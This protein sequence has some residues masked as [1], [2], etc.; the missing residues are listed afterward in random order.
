MVQEITLTSSTR[1]CVS[2]DNFLGYEGENK[3][4]KLV[5]AFTD[6]F[7]DGLGTLNIKRENEVGY[8]ELDKVGETYEF[9]VRNSILGKIG[10]I[11]F[12]VSITKSDGTVIK[13]DQFMKTVKDAIDTDAE[14]PEDYPTWLDMGNA[15]LTEME[16]AIERSE[17]ATE[18]LL[19]DK[20]NGTFN[21][22]DGLNGKS[23]YEIWLLLGNTGTENDF[24]NYLRASITVNGI[25]NVNG[26]ITIKMSNIENNENFITA[27]VNNLTNYYLKT[28]T[29][30]KA[31]VNALIGDISGSKIE[32]VEEL[33]LEGRTDTIYLLPK[34]GATDDIYDEYIYINGNWERIG[35]T[36]VDL[37][38]YLQKT[39]DGS[40]V[41]AT[42]A[43]ASER[44]NIVSGSKLSVIFGVVQKWFS[45]LKNICFSS[46]YTDL[47]DQP[48]I[49]TKISDLE[50]D[51]DF[52]T[53]EEIEDALNSVQDWKAISA[54][55]SYSSFE[56]HTL[57]AS[58]STDLS[59]KLSVGMRI[60]LINNSNI[61]HGI[62]TAITASTI[63]ILVQI[64]KSVSNGTISDVYYSTVKAPYGFP[65][66][67]DEWTVMT[68][69][70]TQRNQ[71][72]PGV[73]QVYNLGGINITIP[74]GIWKLMFQVCYQ[75]GVAGSSNG[76]KYITVGLSTD[77]NTIIADLATAFAGYSNFI[78][79]NTT[80]DCGILSLATPTK[81]YFNARNDGIDSAA[82]SG[83]PIYLLNPDV[84]LIIR[85]VCAYL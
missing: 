4:N 85:A 38:N 42:F 75:L 1:K 34:V 20:E 84:T 35:S 49:P 67:P 12:Q 47:V 18:Q 72:N 45:A 7:V 46:S 53:A 41:T 63:T 40:D 61:I 30:T 17:T 56:N 64:S 9:P 78:R 21:G 58:T 32:T 25:S 26:N 57:I 15:K 3:A 10:E 6:G 80:K 16:E 74:Q 52:V 5:F 31:E 81:Y 68:T 39:G 59:T 11:K 62:I 33:P 2:Q 44:T 50:D 8:V 76:Q 83:M 19:E 82:G 77:T 48:D 29:Y 27:L 55:L 14:M 37:T 71:N 66:N 69:D 13:Y 65:P 28:D 24:I 54:T 22:N 23:A 79:D 70:T 36:A 51:S 73:R 43:T 60:R